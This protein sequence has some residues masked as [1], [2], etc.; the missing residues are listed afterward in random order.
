MVV[1][2]PP[3]PHTHTPTHPHT[4]TP[5]VSTEASS[6]VATSNY[7]KYQAYIHTYINLL[8]FT[9]ILPQEKKNFLQ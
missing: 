9:F 8:N 2:S 3:A 6:G 7:I 4:H 1:D 5:E